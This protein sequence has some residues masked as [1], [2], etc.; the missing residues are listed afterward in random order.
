MKTL[1][2]MRHGKSSWKHPDLSD[3]ERPLTKR[4]IRASQQMGELV[5]LKELVPQRILASSA[6]RAVE[7]AH[8]LG[9]E[10]HCGDNV[11]AVDEFYL[12]EPDVYINYLKTLPDEIERVM[13]VG[14]NPGLESLP[15][16]LSGQV[17]TLPTAVVAHLFLPIT[18]WKNL[19]IDTE[20]ELIDLWRPKELPDD[21]FEKEAEKKPKKVE[22]VKPK[23]KSKKK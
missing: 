7:T 22:K 10:C 21:L 6:V 2:L 11:I 17:E 14:H 15:Q 18:G 13:I 5:A 9:Q 4:G 1:L 8:L 3:H 23:K 19:S 20:G 12:A 16:M